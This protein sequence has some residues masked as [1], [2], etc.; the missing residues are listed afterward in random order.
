MPHFEFIWSDRNLQKIADNDLTAED[1]ERAVR[2]SK[3]PFISE[4]SGRPGYFG[5][6]LDGRRIAV[7]Y[8]QIDEATI[9]VVT[10]FETRGR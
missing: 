2:Q 8:E 4:S 1:C 7:V 9:F 5:S 3:T 10:A 6:A